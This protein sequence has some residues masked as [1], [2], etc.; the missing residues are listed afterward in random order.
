MKLG[1]REVK[2][3]LQAEAKLSPPSPRSV[4]LK[5][6]RLGP[7]HKVFLVFEEVSSKTKGK[8]S[9]HFYSHWTQ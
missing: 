1:F 8:Y 7:I 5:V 4:S 9:G 2:G 3:F 6:H